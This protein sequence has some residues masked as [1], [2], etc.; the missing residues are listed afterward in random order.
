MNIIDVWPSESEL[1][2]F[3]EH[4]HDQACW[5]RILALRYDTAR[6]FAEIEE[7]RGFLTKGINLSTTHGQEQV[8]ILF[9]RGV[10]EYLEALD[11][12]D[13]KHVREE[14][15]DAV[16]YWLCIA[17]QDV[18]FEYSRLS[19]FLSVTL[20]PVFNTPEYSYDFTDG[21]RQAML[22]TGFKTILFAANPLLEKLR[23]RA[24]QNS[25]QS[26]YFDGRPQLYTFTKIMLREII[27]KGFAGSW[28]DFIAY[29]IAKDNV[30]QF[31][32]RSDY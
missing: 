30:L 14:L 16:N 19:E 15:I 21:A 13:P 23:N 10:E 5:E 31:R 9:A 4:P 1:G 24:W 2:P 22:W 29:Y 3:L 11:A 32:I 7:Q 18:E 27:L 8:R 20:N 12:K 17:V 28:E 6:G 26:T 25:A